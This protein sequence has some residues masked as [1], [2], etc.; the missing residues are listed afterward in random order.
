MLRPHHLQVAGEGGGREGDRARGAVGGD[1]EEVDFAGSGPEAPGL[2]EEVVVHAKRLVDDQEKV[3][4]HQADQEHSA[5]CPGPRVEAAEEEGQ[6]V[7]PRPRTN[8]TLRTGARK[9][10]TIGEEAGWQGA[11]ASPGD[12][13]AVVKAEGE[14]EGGSEEGE[15]EGRGEGELRL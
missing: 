15:R 3:G 12:P 9:A 1:H 6:A 7:P 2:V 10:D 13:K 4:H 11:G 5:G 14:E 8:S